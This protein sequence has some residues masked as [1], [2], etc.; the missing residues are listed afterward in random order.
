MCIILGT[1]VG[2]AYG[3]LF[4]FRNFTMVRRPFR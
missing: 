4:L 2:E 1:L 3:G